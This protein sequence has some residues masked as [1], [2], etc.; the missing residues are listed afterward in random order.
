[1][2]CKS[3]VSIYLIGTEWYRE[4]GES[5]TL[6][7]VKREQDTHTHA[8]TNADVN[9]TVTADAVPSPNIKLISNIFGNLVLLYTFFRQR[10]IKSKP[11]FRLLSLSF[12]VSFRL[13]FFDSI[14]R[15]AGKNK[16]SH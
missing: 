12:L 10:L 5:L 16:Y 15:K 6:P 11:K 1:M 3:Q 9:G 14:P 2:S 7:V 8:H 13:S 4:T